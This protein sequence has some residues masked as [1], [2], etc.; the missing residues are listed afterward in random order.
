M[1]RLMILLAVLA[2]FALSAATISGNVTTELPDSV[3]TVTALQPG[4]PQGHVSV[5]VEDGTYVIEELEL[6]TYYVKLEALGAHLFYDGVLFMEDATPIELTETNPW[7]SEINFNLET[8]DLG[9]IIGNVMGCGSCPDGPPSGSVKLYNMLPSEAGAEAIAE[10]ELETTHYAFTEL[11]FGTYYVGLFW[12]GQD[13]IYYEDTADPAL[14]TAIELSIENPVAHEINFDLGETPELGM[15]AGFVDGVMMPNSYT[16]ALYDQL[17]VEPEIEPVA[18]DNVNGHHYAFHNIEFG[19]YYLKCYH[20]DGEVQYYDMQED[21]NNATAVE[22]NVENPVALGINFA[23][24]GNFS[25]S[26]TITGMVTDQNAEPIFE[27]VVHLHRVNNGGNQGGMPNFPHVALTA[28]NGIYS[29]ENIPAGEY[30]VKVTKDGFF[31]EFYEE[32]SHWQDATIITIEDDSELTIDFSLDSLAFYQL[33]GVVL[34]AA[35][36]PLEGTVVFAKGSNC[37]NPGNPLNLNGP[38]AETDAEGNYTLE[39]ATGDYIV[40]ALAISGTQQSIQ[41]YDH[42]TNPLEADIVT[43][44]SDLEGINFDL[45]EPASYENSLSGVVSLEGEPAANAVIVAMSSD[46]TFATTVLADENGYYEFSLPANEYYL[47]ANAEGGLNTFY[48]GVINFQAA[49]T[50]EVTGVVTDINFEIIP[51][52][53]G[54]YFVVD[55]YVNDPNGQPVYNTTVSF[56]DAYG[57]VIATATTDASGYYETSEL[58]VGEIEGLATKVFYESDTETMEVYGNTTVDF[59]IEPM[60]QLSNEGTPDLPNKIATHNYPNPFNPTT[61]ISFNIPQQTNVNVTV[62]NVKGEKVK[63]LVNSALNSGTHTVVWDGEDDNQN[64]VASGVYFY[65]VRTEN[66]TAVKKIMMIK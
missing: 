8:P 22:V 43:V 6:G 41:F 13:P 57:N 16:V 40:G 3:L 28:E 48:P 27:A 64:A 21:P 32:A 37:Q 59:T 34:D 14:A 18:E 15:I 49:E 30:Y 50:V 25:G 12:E 66:S 7:A 38:T 56:T 55:G 2:T 4:N 33:S 51:Q 52:A 11:E 5:E 19:T 26:G 39:L 53:G 44:E 62:Y 60:E 47:A 9:A 23:M 54:G 42:K 1:K 45:P 17:P 31:P 20:E 36:N 61:T 29:L 46:Q 35:G 58:S 10:Y 63:T 24:E 65:K